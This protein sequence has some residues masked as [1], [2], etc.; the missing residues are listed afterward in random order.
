V[1]DTLPTVTAGEAAAPVAVIVGGTAAPV[2]VQVDHAAAA[3]AA[4][5]AVAAVVIAIQAAV[6]GQAAIAIPGTPRAQGARGNFKKISMNQ[7]I[8]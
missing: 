5:A 8:P 6:A 3:A 7:P 2:A 4:A 1:A